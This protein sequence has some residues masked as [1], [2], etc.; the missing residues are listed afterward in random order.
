MENHATIP[1]VRFNLKSHKSQP[2][3]KPILIIAVFRY[4][5]NRLLYT[6]GEK[7][8]L[9]Y[10]NKKTN[11]AKESVHYP[12]SVEINESLEK[13]KREIRTLY[14]KQ[15]IGK[16]ITPQKFKLELDYKLG[17]KQKPGSNQD[18]NV[19]LYEFVERL[20]EDRK[21]GVEGRWGQ[22]WQKFNS[23]L[24]HLKTFG[25]EVYSRE[26]NY[27]DI[28]LEFKDKFVQWCRETQNH[29]ENTIAKNITV[30]KQFLKEARDHHSNNI[31][32]DDRFTH[33]RKFIPKNFPTLDELKK[34]YNH[35]FEDTKLQEAIDLYLLSAFGGGLRWSDI[36]V[37]N[38]KNEINYHGSQV[39]QVFT[40]KGR[41]TKSDN[42]VIIPITPQLRSIL[43]KYEWQLPKIPYEDINDLVRTG[44]KEAGIDRSVL[45]KSG[46]RGIKPETKPLYEEISFHTARYAYITYMINDLGV[47]AEELAKITGQ[48]L[49]VLLKYE[50]GDKMKNASKV[51]DKI[52][53]KLSELRVIKNEAI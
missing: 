28:T 20:I 13:I 26:L 10:W 42:E 52:N 30:I 4:E 7:V 50:Q 29:S 21:I 14:R 2:L 48:S 34:L 24:N 16:N 15:Y 23:T 38:K 44:F 18:N 11:R 51:A 37:L 19:S 41:N 5:G 49:K 22:T 43:N 17:R 3:D 33:P 32:M 1:Q 36:S 35:K 12:E 40:Y 46:I 53:A 47:S 45:K 9:K 25:Q 6:T 31:I 39:L 27:D 8:P